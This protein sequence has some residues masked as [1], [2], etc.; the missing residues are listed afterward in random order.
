M[1]ENGRIAKHVYRFLRWR[2]CCVTIFFRLRRESTYKE[3]LDVK[4]KKMKNKDTDEIKRY[5][6]LASTLFNFAKCFSA[7]DYFC[8]F[9]SNAR[10]WGQEY[11]PV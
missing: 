7:W 1:S 11:L 4:T 10:K 5:N 8:P 6:Y 9:A 3:T 2:A